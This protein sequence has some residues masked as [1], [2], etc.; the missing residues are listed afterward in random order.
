MIPLTLHVSLCL[1]SNPLEDCKEAVQ[2]S[3]APD[4]SIIARLPANAAA[5]A[6]LQRLA[7]TKVEMQ[8]LLRLQFLRAW[9]SWTWLDSFGKGERKATP[10]KLTSL[11][12]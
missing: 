12:V 5:I 2:Q 8:M 9:Y 7:E 3:R 6:I 4:A 1:L 11:M 10:S